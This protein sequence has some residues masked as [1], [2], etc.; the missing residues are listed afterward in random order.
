MYLHHRY[1]HQLVIH[2]QLKGMIHQSLFQVH[3]KVQKNRHHHHRHK[4]V[5]ILRLV[6]LHQHLHNRHRLDQRLVQ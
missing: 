1:H 3:Y 5:V 6:K 4:L 2:Q